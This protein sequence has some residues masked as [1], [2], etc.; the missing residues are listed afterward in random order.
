[1]GRKHYRCH[2][3]ES[4]SLQKAITTISG[5]CSITGSINVAKIWNT[6]MFENKDRRFYPQALIQ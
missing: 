2:E 1:M 5:I 4:P 6:G 3:E